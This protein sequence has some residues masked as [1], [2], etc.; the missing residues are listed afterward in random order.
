MLFLGVQ[1]AVSL[2]GVNSLIN[3]PIYHAISPLP[4]APVITSQPAD[5]TICEGSDASFSVIAS[6]SGLT[7]EWFV[8][9]GTTV[10]SI[11]NN[12]VYTGQGTSELQIS[13]A[14][15]SYNQYK[16]FVEISNGVDPLVRSDTALLATDLLPVIQTQPAKDVICESSD[17][18]FEVSATGTSL[19]YQWYE[20][21][22][23]VNFNPITEDYEINGYAYFETSKL[24]IFN[25]DRS[26][27]N[28][29]YRVVISSGACTPG[30]QSENALLEV[31]DYTEITAQSQ[32]ITVCEGTEAS[33]SVTAGGSDLTYQWKVD[34][35]DGNGYVDI[36]GSDTKYS[37]ALTADLKKT[38]TIAAS[39]DGT[40]Y[41]VYVSGY[42]YPSEESDPIAL[43][44]NASAQ[45]TTQPSDTTVCEDDSTSFAATVSGN[46]LG[47][48]WKKSTDGISWTPLQND[49]VTY[50]GVDTR[51][52]TILKA[53]VAMNTLRFRVDVNSNCSPVAT[54]A[55]YISVLSKPAPSI[56]G[57]ALA[58]PLICGGQTVNLDGNPGSSGSGTYI[59]HEWS[60]DTENLDKSDAQTASFY[61]RDKGSYTLTYTVTDDNNCVG[62][63]EVELVYHR[64]ESDFTSDATPECGTLTVT[65]ENQSSQ[66]TTNYLWDFGDGN[67][68][69]AENPVHFFKNNS[70]S[71]Q[72][73][74]Y[75]IALE[76]IEFINPQLSCRDTSS[77]VITVYPE[78]A[79]EIVLDTAAGCA[80]FEIEMYTLPGASTYKWYFG[81]GES[82]SLTHAVT[83]TFIN[84]GGLPEIYET[85]LVTTSSLGCSA[86]DTVEITVH[87]IGTTN[88]K[89]EPDI[90][91][92]FPEGGS[93]E[94]IFDNQTDVGPWTFTYSF[95][96]GNTLETMSYDDIVHTYTAPGIFTVKLVARTDYCIDSAST[97]VTINPIAPVIGFSS[98]TEGCHPLVVEF[99]NT[100]K[101][102]SEYNWQFG[103]GFTSTQSSPTHTF[104]QPGTYT[105]KLI[106]TGS[107][108]ISQE[109]TDIIVHPT[110]QVFF[111]LAPDSVYV[112]NV[113]VKF[114]NMTSYADEYLWNFGDYGI[115]NEESIAANDN[116]STET[117]PTHIYKYEGWK[118]VSMKASNAYC[119]DSITVEDAV[120]VLAAGDILFPTA[121]SP[122]TEPTGGDVQNL[123]DPAAKNSVFFPGITKQVEE[124]KLY[125]Y[126]RWG[127]RVF[128]SNDINTG[129]DGFINGKRA[130]QGVY[131]WKVAGIYSNGAPFSKSGDVTLIWQ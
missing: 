62:H 50:D 63:D 53:G 26:A 23:G 27:N 46:S 79:P 107:G 52:L 110:P 37:G 99:S 39:D 16:Y 59:L 92:E 101:F 129:W 125:I 70:P 41:K 123:S 117:D 120:K 49:G 88:F 122:G 95:G 103:D 56:S 126:T 91:N 77:Y 12:T 10:S 17:A 93:T 58:F 119:Q 47:Y 51:R 104:N 55:A 78:T 20:S 22:D 29:K 54:N 105:V 1:K 85:V 67:T 121:F 4:A 7:Y 60:G 90:V 115:V 89:A 66:E 130:A 68:S 19:T 24:R 102:A 44:V 32:D 38:T 11:V 112:N 33:F 14:D 131:I 97:V 31:K 82:D 75:S 43:N 2:T 116:T 114:F 128:Q 84:R 96:D 81:D 36:S 5:S 80:P 8:D 21:T 98:L 45:I 74:Y 9:N 76:A 83:H 73:E 100:T 13:G 18:S 34:M 57:D 118:N 86:S 30:V 6:G 72:I 15:Q 61:S 48:Q 64:P 111:S 71:G 3:V 127:E 94:I 25:V 40:S 42:C 124:Y 106:A 28:N 113:P 87:P 35:N 69:I 65:F 108:G 109:T